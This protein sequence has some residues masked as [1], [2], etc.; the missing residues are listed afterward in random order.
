MTSQTSA[1]TRTVSSG[2]LLDALRWR[3]A[4]KVF[5]SS[6]NIPT[7]VWDALEDALVLTPS[8]YGLQPWKFFVITDPAL[9]EELKAHSWEQRQVV[10]C[11]RFVVFAV[12]KALGLED[13][14]RWVARLAEARA[15]GVDSLK[16]YREAMKGNLVDGPRR[17]VIFEWAARQAYIALGNFMTSAAALGVDTCP[18]EGIN[19][20]QYDKI[21]GFEARGYATVVACAAGYRSDQD[22]YA[23]QPKVR[24]AKSQVIENI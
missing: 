12:K 6:K 11:A 14:D 20:A 8:S 21:L 3:Y 23:G 24:Y 10:D 9:R 18:M 15:V 2:T 22:A 17:T 16:G 13:I 1:S 19:P 4:T 5:D 7:P